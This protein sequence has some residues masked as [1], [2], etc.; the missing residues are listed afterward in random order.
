MNWGN[1]IAFS[2][3]VIFLYR[4]AAAQTTAPV[5]DL[6]TV[7]FASPNVAN[8]L[9]FGNI[10]IGLATGTPNI[11]VPFYTVKIG[12]IT[13]PIDLNYHSAGIKV[14]E[15]ASWVGLGWNLDAGGNITREVRGLPDEIGNGYLVLGGQTATYLTGGAYP[16]I[17]GQFLTTSSTGSTGDQDLLNIIAG[18]D[19]TQADLFH[20]SCGKYTGNFFFNQA[21]NIV[22]IPE[23]NVT[24]QY[25]LPSQGNIAFTI[26]TPEG[27][28]YR[29]GGVSEF[30][31]ANNSNTP[32]VSSW[33][34][35]EIDDQYGNQLLFKYA[36]YSYSAWSFGSETKGTYAE[37]DNISAGEVIPES[38]D[39]LNYVLNNVGTYVLDT[40]QT[41]NETIVFYSAANR[42]DIPGENTLDSIKAFNAFTGQT[43][44]QLD[45]YTSYMMGPQPSQPA[46]Y[47]PNTSMRL[48][49]DS[50]LLDSV[51]K[52]TFSYDP[53]ALPQRMSFSQD[54]WGYFNGQSNTNMT[55]YFLEW[56]SPT[57]W[58]YLPGANRLVN[59]A[60]ITAGMLE[61]IVYPTGG[62]TSFTY[63]ANSIQDHVNNLAYYSNP[64][65]PLST[66]IYAST[67][68][69]QGTNYL[70]PIDYAAAS[71]PLTFT[72]QGLATSNSPFTWSVELIDSA[73]M[74]ETYTEIITNGET[75]TPPAGTY[76]VKYT[77]QGSAG[78]TGAPAQ[79]YMIYVNW[80][81]PT[82]PYTSSVDTT[83]VNVPVGG[84]RIKEMDDYDPVGNLTDVHTYQYTQVDGVSSSG[85]IVNYPI[86]NR[87]A[88]YY[89][90]MGSSGPA[91]CV[92]ESN[93]PVNMQ[94]LTSYS[95]VPIAINSGE[96]IGYSRVVESEGLGTR[97]HK[98][99]YT[100]TNVSDD[101]DIKILPQ[102]DFP[103]TP[104][105]S[106]YFNRGLLKDETD[107]KQEAGGFQKVRER[108]NY[109]TTINTFGV[110]NFC[111]NSV[112]AVQ[113]PQIYVQNGT[114][115]GSA[116]IAEMI[117][118]NMA[119]SVYEVMSGYNQLD[120]TAEIEYD[121]ND[122]LKYIR[123]LT[124]Y[125]WTS[126]L[127]APYALNLP[128]S[129]TFVNS[130]GESMISNYTYAFD[131]AGATASTTF[132][133]GIGNL[134]TRGLYTRLVEA[135]TY[136]NFGG[137]QTFLKSSLYSYDP[138][139][140]EISQEY[141]IDNGESGGVTAFQPVSVSG[142]QAQWDANYIL[143]QSNDV[144]DGFGNLLQKHKAYDNLHSYIWDYHASYPVAE[145]INAGEGDVA[146][147]GFEAD[148][149]GNWTFTGSTSYDVGAFAGMYD[150]NLGQ[151]VISR[152]GL[153]SGTS[154]V[155]SYW[156]A[157][158]PCSVTGTVGSPIT[159][160]T[161]G[162]WTY[163]EHQVS[164][165]G[166]VTVGGSATIDELRLYPA[167]QMTTYSYRP[168][169]GV[170]E[171]CD[172]GNRVTHYQ[173]D[174]ASRLTVIRDQDGNII[175][176]YN[177]NYANQP[178]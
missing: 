53:T 116:W 58:I 123:T 11:S 1:R 139:A 86:F 12:D 146:Y 6:K 104:F 10:P 153:N 79:S 102:F 87:L 161:I 28:I 14:S 108:T 5:P 96:V 115:C 93:G 126:P 169:V 105:S 110:Q 148:G 156:S 34:P 151:G 70:Q 152:T 30:V 99:I 113:S 109:Y 27:L 167:A 56:T 43:I 177:Y 142:S 121:Q 165:Q 73:T 92:F 21:G 49:L 155:V 17:S 95:Q 101:P 120:S 128:R 69:T 54:M 18:L 159:G 98:K 85:Q 160:K 114:T 77:I 166:T 3:F 57:A 35:T 145:V 89:G 131:L 32:Y 136:K 42:Q 31:S 59:P 100:Y 4:S 39:N 36:P 107:Y 41:K 48:R 149:T 133:N 55:P 147:C 26:T 127:S 82:Y 52:Y 111:T 125:T 45:L 171:S 75:M 13:L 62:S 170:S 164:G 40:I 71:T 122:T 72:F 61:K 138:V 23:Q 141:A 135:S 94:L 112:I 172:V 88:P 134:M 143:R 46:G 130:K 22:Q 38:F 118:N 84:V 163:Y 67:A 47:A 117:Q 76:L 2:I 7:S 37:D 64:L 97:L 132:D 29:Y 15:D 176:T 129:K 25:T 65:I 83:L 119:W 66:G 74:G 51:Q 68:N 144:Y 50:V 106:Q 173:Y 8:M 162:K 20:Y 103:Y 150:Y 44:H 63:E 168:S 175:K 157:G 81:I 154:Y 19:D 33:F 140:P 137:T 91:G 90:V 16:F 80:S 124:A 78:G 24:I 174:N 60:T 178:H 158:G 9:K